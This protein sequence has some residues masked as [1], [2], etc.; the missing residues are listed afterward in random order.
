M[1]NLPNIFLIGPMGAGKST[2]GR[3]IAM[4]LQRD[5]YDTDIEIENRSGADIAWIYDIE[6]EE[7]YRLREQKVIEELSQLQNIVLATG[8]GAIVAP[9]NRALLGSRGSVIYL[10]ASLSQQY[11]RTRRDARRP[12]LKTENVK[13]RIDELW[14]AREPLYEEIADYVFDT[15]EYAVRTIAKKIIDSLFERF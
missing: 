1:Q 3:A 5:F 15:D 2:I 14:L 11:E 12:M 8:G 9:E 4:E 13:E 7:G 6:G 10:R